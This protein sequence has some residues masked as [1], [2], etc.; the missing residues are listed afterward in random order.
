MFQEL[1]KCFFFP[2]E[3]PPTHTQTQKNGQI[4][5]TQEKKNEWLRN[6]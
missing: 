4:I 5:I 1:S 6:V 2:L 3:Y